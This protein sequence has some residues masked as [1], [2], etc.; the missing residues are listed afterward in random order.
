MSENTKSKSLWVVLALG[1]AAGLV[2]VTHG[3]G[4]KQAEAQALMSAPECQCSRAIT[5][6]SLEQTRVAH[7]LCGGMSCVLSTQAKTSN[8][9]CAR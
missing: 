8:M 9:E 3:F 6:P 7:C 1:L 2:V 5:I 4:V